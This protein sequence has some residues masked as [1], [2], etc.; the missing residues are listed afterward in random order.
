M[1][2]V[3]E[4]ELIHLAVSGIEGLLIPDSNR[5]SIRI[6]IMITVLLLIISSAFIG[7]TQ[8][9]SRVSFHPS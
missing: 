2:D 8:E 1:T 5:N 6:S 4:K 9:G 7:L 3:P